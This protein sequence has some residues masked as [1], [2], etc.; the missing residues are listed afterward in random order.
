MVEVITRDGAQKDAEEKIVGS[1]P[2]V[3]AAMLAGTGFGKTRVLCRA[4]H[5]L[6]QGRLLVSVPFEHL[7]KRFRDEYEMLGLDISNVDFVCHVSLNGTDMSLYDT[8][9]VD[10]AHLALTDRCMEVY[11]SWKGNLVMAT[12]TLPDDPFLAARLSTT[13]R[14]VYSISLDE[15]VK[16]GYVAPYRVVCLSIELTEEERKLYKTVSANFGYWKGKLGLDP[17]NSAQYFLKSGDS[18]QKKAALG[19][20][21]AIRQRKELVDHA[22][23]KLDVARSLCAALPGRK[24]VFGGDNTFSDMLHREIPDSGIYHSSLGKGKADSAL[25]AFRDGG[26]DVLVSTKALNQGL[27]VPDA[28]VGIICGLTSKSLTMVQR[29]GRLVRIDPKDPSKTGY[30]VVVY[31]KESQEEVWLKEA[32]SKLSKAAVSW[33]DSLTDLTG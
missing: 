26:T 22:A 20:F 14:I 8:L 25:Q 32:L 4:G 18:D 11:G 9:L 1:G 21:R 33:T 16:R 29:I 13:C 28:S 30:V 19:F 31:V 15:C 2:V 3:R 24:L 17:F 12:A 23:N 6:S 7:K 10:E 27:D 5:R